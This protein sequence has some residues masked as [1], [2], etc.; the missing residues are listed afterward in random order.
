MNRKKKAKKSKSHPFS[1]FLLFMFC[2]R[3]RE[4]DQNVLLSDVDE[5]KLEP[6]KSE[7]SCSNKNVINGSEVPQTNKPV[8]KH[9]E[10]SDGKFSRKNSFKSACEESSIRSTPTLT[11][12]KLRSASNSKLA[13]PCKAVKALTS[14]SP[15]KKHPTGSPSKSMTLNSHVTVELTRTDSSEK[16]KKRSTSNL[17]DDL[18][19]LISLPNC[20]LE[21]SPRRESENISKTNTR[22][23]RRTKSLSDH[24]SC[25]NSHRKRSTT[26]KLAMPVFRP[27]LSKKKLVKVDNCSSNGDIKQ[28]SFD[29]QLKSDLERDKLNTAK[30]SRKTS[31]N[32]NNLEQMTFQNL[33]SKTSLNVSKRISAVCHSSEDENRRKN[34]HHKEIKNSL[35]EQ[36]IKLTSVD[37]TPPGS[38]KRSVRKR[39]RPYSCFDLNK[40]SDYVMLNP[41]PTP[42]CKTKNQ[43]PITTPEFSHSNSLY[44]EHPS[45]Q[46]VSLHP[47]K[48]LNSLHPIQKRNT[49]GEKEKKFSESGSHSDSLF[50]SPGIDYLTEVD[51]ILTQLKKSIRKQEAH[52]SPFPKNPKTLFPESSMKRSKSVEPIPGY[53][54]QFEQSMYVDSSR[55]P[56]ANRS[57]SRVKYIA[58]KY[59][60]Y[61]SNENVSNARARSY[62][63][64][65]SA[66]NFGYGD[67]V[68][69]SPKPVS[70][71]PESYAF[72]GVCSNQ[73]APAS[74]SSTNFHFNQS[75]S[76]AVALNSPHNN[77]NTFM[78]SRTGD[79]YHLNIIV[80]NP[81][82]HEN[83]SKYNSPN[84]KNVSNYSYNNVRKPHVYYSLDV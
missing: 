61:N 22:D 52:N 21:K 83:S 16:L 70:S 57:R 63:E 82:N 56:P 71:S 10:F 29:K 44:F 4:K 65:Q 76:Q 80:Q 14:F 75:A 20:N 18:K 3:R 54:P 55:I 5:V 45:S 62:S 8:S 77:N 19:P 43:F 39:A 9:V 69:L 35:T 68:Y 64:L 30:E 6:E 51:E 81:I 37:M 1:F 31:N 24:Q 41:I 46:K 73:S 79:Y 72:D 23:L 50:K 17:S 40:D 42:D 74:S 25:D 26:S 49:S 12:K 47:S 84:Q 34:L 13:S 53:D 33:N 28:N 36:L 2:R 60:M 78:T 59:N 58:R 27:G 66:P 7:H 32:E 38:T 48:S 15:L 67:Y 11:S